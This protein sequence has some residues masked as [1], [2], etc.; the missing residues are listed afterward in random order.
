MVCFVLQVE[1]LL[2]GPKLS[3]RLMKE[4]DLITS[5]SFL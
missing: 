5:L 2:E 3:A 4:Q 1:S